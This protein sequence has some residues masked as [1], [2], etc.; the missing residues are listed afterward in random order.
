MLFAFTPSELAAI[1]LLLMTTTAP[2]PHGRLRHDSTARR[3]GDAIGGNVAVVH[4]E[5]GVV[6]VWGKQDSDCWSGIEPRDVHVID[7]ERGTAYEIDADQPAAYS[8]DRQISQV[9]RDTCP[10]DVN[11]VCPRG[12]N[13]AKGPTAVDRNRLR[14]RDRAKATRVEAVD[15]SAGRRLGDRAGKRLAGR[16]AAA[17]VGI[18]ADAGN[19]RPCRLSASW[20]GLQRQD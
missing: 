15:L 14:D 17:W 19:P 6:G 2:P 7:I 4:L 5:Q 3:G 10:I 1:L 16:R 12:Q 11:A 20:H 9:H 13:R 18:I 8:V